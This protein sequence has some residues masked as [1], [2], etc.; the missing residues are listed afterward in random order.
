MINPEIKQTGASS[1]GKY[2]TKY[3]ES[4]IW[5]IPIRANPNK[6][7]V[8]FFLTF[9]EVFVMIYR[10]KIIMDTLEKGIII[11]NIVNAK[12]LLSG[13][14]REI[15]AMMMPIHVIIKNIFLVE[16]TI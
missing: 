14:M 9:P 8:A 16:V 13:R 6:I 10:Y 1:R 12:Y 5:L 3:S 15:N 2:L 7:N 11:L 4:I